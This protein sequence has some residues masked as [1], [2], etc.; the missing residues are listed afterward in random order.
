MSTIEIGSI[1]IG[2]NGI[3]TSLDGSSYE[4]WIDDR[5]NSVGGIGVKH[6]FYNASGQTIKYITFTYEA[7][8][9]VG[10]AVTCQTSGKIEAAG[11]L[12]GPME[13]FE[14]YNVEWD[15]LWYN[16]TISKA[17]I[18]EVHIQ[19]MDNSEETIP[20]EQLLSM[21]DANSEFSKQRDARKAAEEARRQQQKEEALQAVNAVKDA[22]VSGLK[23]LFKKK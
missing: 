7:Y 4:G 14:E 11:K 15:A 10:D 23:G 19:F 9:Q 2:H 12:T 18:K 20:G 6:D 5:P 1:K 17:A 21:W 8:N 3:K 22:V 16:P 13:P